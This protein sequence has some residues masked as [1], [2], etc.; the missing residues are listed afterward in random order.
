MEQFYISLRKLQHNK[1][2]VF[3]TVCNNDNLFIYLCCILTAVKRQKK[4][5]KTKKTKRKS[6]LWIR[7]LG[8]LG[9]EGGGGVTK[10]I[11]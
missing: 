6:L 2:T 4:K 5:K 7:F 8:G 11:L 10:I 9:V 1:F 3:Y